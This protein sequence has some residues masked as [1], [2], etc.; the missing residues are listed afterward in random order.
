[1][2]AGANKLSFKGR[3]SRSKR[4]KPGRYTVTDRATTAAGLKS[5]R[6]TLE[7]HDPE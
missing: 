2:R 4:L 7:L 6:Q 1:V 5:A 3:I